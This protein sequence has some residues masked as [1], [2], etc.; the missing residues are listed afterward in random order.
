[1][2]SLNDTS[3]RAP[4]SESRRR[5]A[6][7]MPVSPASLGSEEQTDCIPEPR[8]VKREQRRNYPPPLRLRIEKRSPTWL[9]LTCRSRPMQLSQRTSYDNDL[10]L[11]RTSSEPG[12]DALRRPD[13]QVECERDF[14]KA[15]EPEAQPL[16]RSTSRASWSRHGAQPDL[17]PCDIPTMPGK[18]WAELEA[19]AIGAWLLNN[20]NQRIRCEDAPGKAGPPPIR[21]ESDR[22]GRNARCPWGS[23]KLASNTRLAEQKLDSIMQA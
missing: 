8:F 6:V 17:S 23:G 7:R 20:R 5:L 22:I 14:A 10:S 15:A 16:V 18:A 1:M 2:G 21:S 13:G 12:Q 9:D 3:R 19:M 4:R 11:P